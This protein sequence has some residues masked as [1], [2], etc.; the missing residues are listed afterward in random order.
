MDDRVELGARI[1]HLRGKLLSQRELADKAQ[2]SV[3]LIRKLEQGRR[4]TASIASLQRIA[5][6]LDVNIAELLGKP[7]PVLSADPAAGVVAI[8][9]A[10]TPVDDLLDLDVIEGT[11]L[12]LDEAER[13]VTYLWGAYWA[14]RYELLSTLLPNA[15]MQ[16]RATHRA[17]PATEKTRAAH[18]L[19]R[20]YQ[21]AGD[22]L[23][24]LGHQDAA[25]LAIR[26]ALRAAHESDD[27]LLYAAMRVSVA[28]QLLVQG[29]YEESERVAVVAA[30]GVEPHGNASESELSAYGILSVTAATAAARSQKRDSARQLLDVANE[31]AGRLGYDRADHQTTFGPAKVAMLA[32]DVHVVQ[33]DFSSALAAAKSLPRDAALPLASRARHLADVALSNLRLGRDDR[34]L[35]TVL[36]M[37]QLA[38]DWIK[39][40][41]LPRQ[42]VAELVERERRVSPQLRELALRLGALTG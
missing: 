11:P 4:H 39:Y 23:V 3:D 28:W 20:A 38:P 37:E 41:T 1:R 12:T 32:V 35:H 17:V 36:T 10:L 7:T 21:A 24:H 26:E 31:T 42:V 29:R 2:V 30:R 40:Q 6:A 18:A 14:G 33:D 22:T 27:P 16:M 15:L 9:R 25:F 13:T 34:A 19:A 5:K 8:R